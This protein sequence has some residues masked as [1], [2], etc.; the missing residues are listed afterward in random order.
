M[1]KVFFSLAIMAMGLLMA[2]CGNKAEANNNGDQD[3]VP[4][5]GY[6]TYE[7]T[8][9]SVSVPEEFK[10]SYEA[11]SDMARFDSDAKHTLDD[12]EEVSSSAT[13]DVGFL[14]D[15]ATPDKVKETATTM[16]FSQE[17][18]GE[19]CEEP[20]IDGNIILMRQYGVADDVKYITERWW[21]VSESGKNISGNI[22]YPE[23]E[24]KFYEGVGAK[25]AKS[26]KIK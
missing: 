2:S 5:E 21:I 15:G 12:G 11:S 4:A 25:I 17:A 1:K 23:K 14:A 20:V 22:F 24:A 3:G 16:K 26:I 7:F 19:T 6:K 10:T 18:T 9:F 8:N 13:I